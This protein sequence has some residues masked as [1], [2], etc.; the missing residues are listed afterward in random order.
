MGFGL[1]KASIKPKRSKQPTAARTTRST[2]KNASTLQRLG[3]QVCNL[4]N[5][6]CHTPRM[7]PTIPKK[8]I[9]YFLTD[10]PGEWDDKNGLPLSAQ[11]GNMVREVI[12][13]DYDEDTDCAYDN[14]VRT[15]P[16][17]EINKDGEKKQR[18]ITWQEIE[19][20]RNNIIESI[21]EAKP[22]IIIGLGKTVLSWFLKNID[23]DGMRGRIFPV[24]IGSH[25]CWFMPVYHPWFLKKESYDEKNL[26]KS[27][28]GYCF[29]MDVKKAFDF[30]EK[31]IK[32]KIVSS[33]EAKENIKT[34]NGNEEY[35]FE[36][37]ITH[38][39][40]A[41]KSKFS[42]ID[43]ETFPLRPYNSD[44][45]L[46]S[47]SISYFIKKKQIT[48][49][50]S[51]EHKD[52][53]WSTS[54]LSQLKEHLNTYLKYNKGVKIAHNVP[55][56]L[57]WFMYLYDINI[58]DHHGWEDTMMQ[59]HFIDERRGKKGDSITSYQSLNFLCL[60]HFGINLKSLFNLNMKDLKTEHISD[61]L[62]YNGID[63]KY[64]L[65]LYMK[66]RKILKKLKMLE[67][68][69]VA[70]SR[71]PTVAL[72]H[73]FGI[74]VNQNTLKKHQKRLDKKIKK[75]EKRISKLRVI[76]VFEK[77][78]G[79][80]NPGS[81]PK[82]LI[83]FRDYLK[84]D[85]I[86]IS[87][88]GAKVIKYS[89]DKNILDKIDHPLAKNIVKL[90]NVNKLKSTYV[91]EFMFVK[92]TNNN[93]GKLVYD[94]GNL[95]TTFNTTFAE[96]GRTSSDSPNMQNFP[97]RNDS[98]V[99]SSVVP[100]KNKIFVAADYGQ[101]EWCT[102]CCCSLDKAMIEATWDGYD[103]H[104][105]WAQRIGHMYPRIIGGKSNL[106]DKDVMKKFR[107]TVKGGMVFPAMFGAMNKTI[108]SYLKIPE[109][110][111]N[112]IMDEFWDN[113]HG[114]QDWQKVLMKEY[115]STG[116]VK[117]P[118]GRRRH[119]PMT[120]NQAINYPIQNAAADITCDSM[121][122][123]SELALETNMLHVHPILNIHDD[124][125]FCVPDND[126]VLE[127]A[128]E[129]IYKQMLMIPYSWINVPISVEVSIGYDWNNM[130]K[131]GKF[132]SHKDL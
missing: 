77:E 99:R 96:T 79:K 37:V 51:L 119:Y 44:A 61:I 26:L 59:A 41:T 72:M 78:H 48:F 122:R 69:K 21:E 19:C 112:T 80:F 40:E 13:N 97:K 106:K 56:E 121:V 53:K 11:Y 116:Y 75:L 115:Y 86:I 71:Q 100:G 95:H 128:I 107:G 62:L 132:F 14:I 54:Q 88:P 17:S 24:K 5:E 73:N 55:F 38:L 85:E 109:D 57:E 92:D 50:F 1:S 28:F 66:Q 46:L 29:K 33:K 94:D 118:N 45:M 82:V 20:C 58:V 15:R 101:L 7:A 87:E 4:K 39:K 93:R 12:P 30:I 60:L 9:C 127:E 8:T 117:A 67:A 42:A 16:P 90:R 130:N 18:A 120:K 113:F 23:E 105:E 64:E 25:E 32:P 124:L 2:P 6:K 98:W 52:A 34:Y 108:A 35:E 84:R 10:T 49:A 126:Q 102:G 36:K 110:L 89:V 91:D 114:L 65:L 123:L 63:A 70:K 131:V 125:T 103:V 43:V 83:V 31:D 3:C 111:I 22:L 76:K 74:P 68:F 81:N 47:L 104:M 129:I 27:R